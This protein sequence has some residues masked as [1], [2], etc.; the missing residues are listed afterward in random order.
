MIMRQFTHAHLPKRH[1]L[2]T[3]PAVPR[4]AC[5]DLFRL[6]SH[7]NRYVDNVQ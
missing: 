5:A 3:T 4:L 7:I 6:T 2:H 1:P